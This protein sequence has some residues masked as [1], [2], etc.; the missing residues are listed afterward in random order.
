VWS[1]VDVRGCLTLFFV[2]FVKKACV[3]DTLSMVVDPYFA[4]PES[5][6]VMSAWIAVISYALWTN[7]Y[8]RDPG[9]L[10]SSIVLDRKVYSIIG[11]MPR[12]FEF[13]LGSGHLDQAQVWVPMSLTFRDWFGRNTPGFTPVGTYTLTLICR[14]ALKSSLSFGHFAAQV[15]IT[16]SGT[17]KALGTAAVPF[18]TTKGEKDPLAAVT[19]SPNAAT[20]A[21]SGGSTAAPAASGGAAGGTSPSPNASVTSAPGTTAAS[22]QPGESGSGV[23]VILLAIGALL[24]AGAGAIAVRSRQGSLVEP[25]PGR[26]GADAH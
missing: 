10:A 7:R 5:F 11:V 15:T 24:L 12:S 2:G 19:T 3:G 1:A 25:T 22:S 13:P 21:P 6:T 14:D 17:Y 16:K 8:H 23:R 18:N 4:A 9:V 20:G 26:H